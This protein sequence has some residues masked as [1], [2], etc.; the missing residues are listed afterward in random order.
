M[1]N[2]FHVDDVVGPVLHPPHDSISIRCR[3]AMLLTAV[4]CCMTACQRVQIAGRAP[5]AP[6]LL[7]VSTQTIP[8][9][10]GMSEEAPELTESHSARMADGS[11][12]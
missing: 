2:Q 1:A 9:R 8:I 3:S 4:L 10:L 5:T 11:G 7:P 12:R 6:A